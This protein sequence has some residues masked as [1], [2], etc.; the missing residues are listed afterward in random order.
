MPLVC[1]PPLIALLCLAACG[2]RAPE[3]GAAAAPASITAEPIFRYVQ[4]G[5]GRVVLGE[6]VPVAVLKALGARAGDTIVLLPRPASDGAERIT[7]YLSAAGVLRGAIFDY[8]HGAD[9]DA[10]VRDYA[11]R[12]GRPSR[13]EE[14]RAGEEPADVATWVDARTALVLRRDPNRNA[15]TVRSELWDR[16]STG[17]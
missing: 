1:I 13:T 9:F 7:L 17:R 2:E 16:A 14:R 10:I 11:A 15:W 5:P 12:L 8:A 3:T 6:R 4:V